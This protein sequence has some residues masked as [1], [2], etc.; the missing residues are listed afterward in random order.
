M[1]AKVGLLSHDLHQRYSALTVDIA[2]DLAIAHK[3]QR[4]VSPNV[5][6]QRFKL[7]FVVVQMNLVLRGKISQC[8][9]EIVDNETDGDPLQLTA[10]NR[11]RRRRPDWLWGILRILATFSCVKRNLAL[12]FSPSRNL[13]NNE[14][15]SEE[16][17]HHVEAEDQTNGRV[18]QA[19]ERHQYL[20][21]ETDFIRQ[22]GAHCAE[23]AHH[24][25]RNESDNL[26]LEY[27]HRGVNILFL[28]DAEI[29]DAGEQQEGRRQQ[30]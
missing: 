26:N 7:H 6:P 28:L 14:Y 17:Y 22:I 23:A 1:L 3:I 9:L 30:V 5:S 12:W 16:Q 24:K 25:K 13:A 8:S 21:G 10:A 29:V 20:C 19:V 27:V 4:P 18:L 11:L 15:N 2:S